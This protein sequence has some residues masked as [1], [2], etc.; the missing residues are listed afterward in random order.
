MKSEQTIRRVC[1]VLVDRANY[2]RMHP[3]M[4]AIKANPDL[5]LLVL[6]SGTMLLERFGQAEKIVEADG[7][8]ISS[9]VYME[10]EGS[11]P[12]TMAKSI[13]VGIIEFSSE[14]HRLKPDLVL[15]IGDRYEA[16][17]AAI[18]AAYMNIPIAHVQGGEVSGSIDESARHAITKFAHLHF[19][20]TARSAEYIIKL[21]ERPDC[22]F[23]VGCPAG[24]Y[25]MHL[26][27]EL[28]VDLFNRV[29][30]GGSIDLSQPF[31]LV[32]YHPTTTRFGTERQQAEQLMIALNELAYP[33]VWIWPNIDAGA[34]EISKSIR[35]Y[36]ERHHTSNQWLHLIKNLDPVTFQ[37]CL[38]RASCAVGNSS[39]FIRDSS[40]SGTPVVLVGERQRGREHGENLIAAPPLSSEIVKAVRQQLKH[41]RYAPST[42]Y[43]NGTASNQIVERLKA[44]SPYKQK[45][46][47]YVYDHERSNS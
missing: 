26:D 7:F 25:I 40:F 14:F 10:L 43:G 47:Q 45:M 20:S 39:S 11:V 13:G 46:L 23:N 38:K 9:R 1:V 36:R 15:I 22:V 4:R 18:S 27:S 44:F 3:V 21:G 6:C 35:S 19:P 29:G 8:E 31:I 33:T 24:D 28:P 30:V 34:D 5:D 32:I 16:L 41:G 12:T 17:A 42:L 37:K 2:G